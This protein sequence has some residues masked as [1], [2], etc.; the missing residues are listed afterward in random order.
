[1]RKNLGKLLCGLFMSV[2][3]TVSL[4]A[5][6]SIMSAEAAPVAAA[7]A[8]NVD[9][10]DCSGFVEL[11]EAVP[12]VILE[13][14]YYS[15]YNFVGDRIAGYQAPRV[16]MTKE[17]AKALKEVS[18]DVMKQGYRLKIYDAYRPQMAVDNFVAWA[19]NLGDKRMKDYFYPQVDK[20]RLFA[21][22]Y[23]AAKSGHSRSDLV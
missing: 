18:D 14:R 13:P 9:P 20:T 17:A 12:D 23:I 10:A 5:T 1:M 2:S 4:A 6:E 21:D 11:S 7:V 19:E 3:L 15:T 8:G 22:G 16:F